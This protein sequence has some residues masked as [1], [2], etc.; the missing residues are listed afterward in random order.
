MHPPPW[1]PGTQAEHRHI[2]R[3]TP[4][5][6]KTIIIV[7]L[8]CQLSAQ[9]R[10]WCDVWLGGC[11]LIRIGGATLVMFSAL[12]WITPQAVQQTTEDGNRVSS[13]LCSHLRTH[14]FAHAHLIVIHLFLPESYGGVP[15]RMCSSS[16]PKNWIP[17]VQSAET[18]ACREIVMAKSAG[19]LWNSEQPGKALLPYVCPEPEDI[20]KPTKSYGTSPLSKRIREIFLR[21]NDIFSFSLEKSVHM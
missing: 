3:Q 19:D 9:R 6:A 11:F 10:R 21:K 16:C 20:W 2:F 18:A 15:V 17:H 5:S 1:E 14:R 7:R 4:T 12:T 8:N 13:V